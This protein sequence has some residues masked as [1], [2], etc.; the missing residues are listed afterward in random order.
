MF[1]V[2]TTTVDKQA[3]TA[4]SVGS[5]RQQFS[6]KENI[7]MSMFGAH[8]LK[9]MASF[10][11]GGEPVQ[12]F[13]GGYLFLASDKGAEVL[14]KNTRLQQSL[15]ASVAL[16]SP[17]QLNA[18]FPWLST[19]GVACGA[20]GTANEGWFDPW[21]L[22]CSFKSQVPHYRF[23]TDSPAF[24]T[25]T[26]RLLFFLHARRLSKVPYMFPPLLKR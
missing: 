23:E 26:R 6:I 18:K 2:C 15:G 3:S 22:L 13:E 24:F 10:G 5:I 4:L 16:L 19:S 12:F 25:L 21:Q 11:V 8:F 9:N 7:L 20:L 17:K 14:T 1:H